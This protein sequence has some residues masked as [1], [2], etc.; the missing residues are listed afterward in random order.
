[1]KY[2]TTGKKGFNKAW[3]K[4]G[5]NNW[6][7]ALLSIIAMVCLFNFLGDDFSEYNTQIISFATYL[8]ISLDLYITNIFYQ[9]VL[10]YMEE[11]DYMTTDKKRKNCYKNL[12][13]IP[14]D[15]MYKE[16]DL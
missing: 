8:I 1:M 6:G 12:E 14:D 9:K 16:D 10:E 4:A 11:H 3:M 5:L 7:Y 13:F 15:K 2:Y